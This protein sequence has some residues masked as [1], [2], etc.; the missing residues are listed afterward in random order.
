MPKTKV[1][2]DANVLISGILFCGNQRQILEFVI[3]GKIDA[4]ISP[5][6]FTEFKEVLIRLKLCVTHSDGVFKLQQKNS[7]ADNLYRLVCFQGG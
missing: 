1:V 7:R 3:Q 5:A 6:I 4:Y 2:L